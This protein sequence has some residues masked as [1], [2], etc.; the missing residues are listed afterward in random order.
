MHEISNTINIMTKAI[1]N[2]TEENK[3]EIFDAIQKMNIEI[4]DN[5]YA[6]EFIQKIKNL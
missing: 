3:D 6:F 1:Q 2:I 5:K 4:K